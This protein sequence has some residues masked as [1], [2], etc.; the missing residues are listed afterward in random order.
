MYD[1]FYTVNHSL[2]IA[3]IYIKSFYSLFTLYEKN[4]LDQ[5]AYKITYLQSYWSITKR[6]LFLLGKWEE[7]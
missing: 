6:M 5:L 1:L 7:Q 3:C 2:F 4:R